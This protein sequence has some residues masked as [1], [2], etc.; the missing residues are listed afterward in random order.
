MSRNSIYRHAR[1]AELL[2]GPTR[3]A[4]LANAAADESRNL[5][6]YL[7]ITRG[8]LFNSLLACAEAGD[9]HGVA[10]ISGQL[11]SA[12]RDLGRVTG[13]LRQLSGLTINQSTVNIYSD[14]DF[15]ALQEGL[16]LLARKHPV[17]RDDVLR[18]LQEVSPTAPPV[19]SNGSV[20]AAS[21]SSP[22]MIECEAAGAP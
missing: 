16:V 12:L 19:G 13:E 9:R 1:K 21:A 7:S 11:L 2:A 8:V 4:S 5:L 17:V 22:L 6:D 15:L 3:V 20:Y 18:L 14:P 10:H